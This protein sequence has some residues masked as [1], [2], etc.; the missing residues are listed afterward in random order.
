MYDLRPAIPV[1][2]S[3]QATRAISSI[4]TTLRFRQLCRIRGPNGTSRQSDGGSAAQ[5]FRAIIAKGPDA[6][7][8]PSTNKC[9][10]T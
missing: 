2:G 8:Y 4:P 6:D 1:C 7:E 9:I 3:G 5:Q 10:S